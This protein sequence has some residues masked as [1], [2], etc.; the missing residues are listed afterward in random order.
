MPM[1]EVGGLEIV[2]NTFGD[3]DGLIA[4]GLRQEDREFLAAK[5]CRDIR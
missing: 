4:L 3:R 2:T 1:R 5:S